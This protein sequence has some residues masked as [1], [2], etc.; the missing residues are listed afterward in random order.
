M[1]KKKIMIVGDSN[2]NRSIEQKSL[3]YILDL[4]KIFPLSN[5]SFST[6]NINSLLCFFNGLF[7]VLLFLNVHLLQYFSFMRIF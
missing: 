5:F 7:T 6:L 4:I 1:F 3:L 2:E